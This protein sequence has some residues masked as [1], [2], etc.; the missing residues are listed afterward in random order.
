MV[1]EYR[2]CMRCGLRPTDDLTP[3]CG[4]CNFEMAA[5]LVELAAKFAAHA[6]AKLDG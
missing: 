5:D 3:R 1:S 2:P 4:W 6:I